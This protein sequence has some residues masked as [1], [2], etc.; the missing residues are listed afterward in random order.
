[1]AEKEL[2]TTKRFK[3]TKAQEYMLAAVLGA[4]V[5]FGVTL[6]L[7]VHFTQ[8]I[9][10]NG[11][12]LSA[13]EESTVAFSDT[14]KTIGVC[15]KPAEEVYTDKEIAACDPESVNIN[16]NQQTLRYNIL[17]NLAQNAALN[18]VPK[19]A[20]SLCLNSEGRSYTAEELQ[21]RLDEANEKNDAAA[22]QEASNLVRVCSALRIIPDA[23][24]ATYNEEA[25]LA[26][27]NKLFIISNWTFKSISP[28]GTSNATINNN[29]KAISVSLL[30]DADTGTTMNVLHNVER[31]I[32]EFNIE[33]ATIEWGGADSLKLN[34]SA[35]AYYMD[36]SQI[37]KGTNV[38]K[39]GDKK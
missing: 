18:S 3:I 30:V 9:S 13:L 10:L 38:I 31:S 34:A 24:P 1:M 16:Q 4:S 5:I 14:I 23:L 7:L 21:K 2:S 11:R 27:L 6:A 19:E 33:R 32:R 26:S 36:R 28:N 25:L 22:I 15:A 8:K 20:D 35:T 39:L 17:H 29:L 37:V 12:A